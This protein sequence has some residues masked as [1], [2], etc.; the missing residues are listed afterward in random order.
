MGRKVGASPPT[1]VLP[2]FG[3]LLGKHIGEVTRA[4]YEAR[5]DGVFST[6]EEADVIRRT[7]EA[8]PPWASFS[9]EA[10]SAGVARSTR[11]V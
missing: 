2:H 11:L 9:T 7:V 5:A 6:E 3:N 8:L 1:H 4:A 10:R